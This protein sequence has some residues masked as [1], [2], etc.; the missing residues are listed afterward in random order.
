MKGRTG[1]R[2]QVYSLL[3]VSKIL[4][5]S[6]S[7]FFGLQVYFENGLS[8]VTKLLFQDNSCKW[9]TNSYHRHFWLSLLSEWTFEV[10]TC[11]TIK[12]CVDF[13]K[14][15][16]SRQLMVQNSLWCPSQETFLNKII[17]IAWIIVLTLGERAVKW[18]PVYYSSHFSVMMA[19]WSDIGDIW[20]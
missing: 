15:S 10:G 11:V 18:F 13:S 9:Q 14:D 2:H 1:G 5:T 12:W 20:S 6:E 4:C 16:P 17:Q 3:F 7:W 19:G 8:V